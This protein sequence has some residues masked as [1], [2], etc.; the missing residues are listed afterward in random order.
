MEVVLYHPFL[1]RME[2]VYHPVFLLQL[3]VEIIEITD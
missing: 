2:V 1:I 3:G